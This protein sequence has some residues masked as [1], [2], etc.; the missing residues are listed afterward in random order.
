MADAF[1]RLLLERFLYIDER[2][3]CFA[4]CHGN[5]KSSWKKAIEA[6]STEVQVAV[7]HDKATAAYIDEYMMYMLDH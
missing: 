6:P 7:M 3:P 1:E 2:K 4:T 5:P